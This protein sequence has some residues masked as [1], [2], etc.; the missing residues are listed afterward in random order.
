MFKTKCNNFLDS[1]SKMREE[2]I[3]KKVQETLQKEHQPYVEELIKTKQILIE[4]ETQKVE[5]EIEKLRK[6]LSAKVASYEERTNRAIEED[7][8]KVTKKARDLACESYD[9]FILGVSRLVDETQ[10]N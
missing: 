9:K 1:I 6:S 7:K 3:E 5:E 10:I 2:A 8:E 4:E